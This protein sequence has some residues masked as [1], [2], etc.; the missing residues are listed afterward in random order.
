MLL[1]VNVCNAHKTAYALIK[2]VPQKKKMYYHVSMNMFRK[3][4][5]VFFLFL[6]MPALLHNV[7][8]VTYDLIAPE[9]KLH[10]G[11]EVKFTIYIDT[12][13]TTV[14]TGQIGVTYET[15]YLGYVSTTPGAAMTS[16]AVTPQEAGKLLLTGT[17]TAGFSGND[18]FAYLN[19]KII[20][21]APGETQLCVLW[22]P[23]PSPTVTPTAPPGTPQP[24]NPQPTVLP[25][26]GDSGPKDFAGTIGGFL[27]I[28]A[29]SLFILKR[30]I[31]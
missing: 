24:T 3:L 8:A 16:V 20:A 19:F 13:G 1:S 5:V 7:Y 30:I 15:Q 21:D 31:L 17:N 10:R 27:I 29:T 12:E 28:G 25:K 2:I 11:D 14:T 18:V 6:F 26:T 4:S 23:S 9:G 22:A